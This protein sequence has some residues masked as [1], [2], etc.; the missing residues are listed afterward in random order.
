[1]LK[2]RLH[3]VQKKSF[4][5]GQR[6]QSYGWRMCC[7]ATSNGNL[8]VETDIKIKKEIWDC[9]ENQMVES[10]RETKLHK[11]KGRSKKYLKGNEDWKTASTVVKDAARK[12][13]DDI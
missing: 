8:L 4:E 5:G 2:D 1:M 10:E 6:L 3:H 9:P 11:V 7:Q 12:V 13:R